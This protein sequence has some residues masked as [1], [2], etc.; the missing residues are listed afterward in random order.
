M[1][2]LGGR[3]VNSLDIALHDLQGI[4]PLGALESRHHGVS[5]IAA[6]LLP[7][8][9]RERQ[10]R[11]VPAFLLIAGSSVCFGRVHL[12]EAEGCSMWQGATRRHG[13]QEGVSNHSFS[14]A[15]Q[16][17]VCTPMMA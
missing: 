2:F 11:P 13:T 6:V 4:G 3:H 17:N 7:H 9:L 5:E 8:F 12:M 10:I 14:R 16:V 1:L 15:F